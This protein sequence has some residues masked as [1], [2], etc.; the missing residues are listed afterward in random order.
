MVE[1][2][3]LPCEDFGFSCIKFSCLKKC[4]A[5][6]IKSG[7]EDRLLALDFSQYGFSIVIILR[8]IS[9]YNTSVLAWGGPYFFSSHLV[10][11]LFS[12]LAAQTI[13]Y[14]DQQL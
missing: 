8:L 6:Y 13:W 10:E 12:I 2:D 3:Q 14:L 11:E 1:V 5:E 4:F 9:S 7:D